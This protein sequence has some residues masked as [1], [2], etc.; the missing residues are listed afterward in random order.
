MAINKKKFEE[1]NNIKFDKINNSLFEIVGVKTNESEHLAA[2]PYSY[3]K[4]VGRSLIKNWTFLICLVL[5]IV[6]VLLAI[7]V[8]WNKEPVPANPDLRPGTGVMLPSLDHIFGLGT[9]GEDFWI[10]IWAG[11]RT[12]LAFA[13]LLAFIQLTIGILLGSIWGYFKKTD[14]FFIQITNF[15]QLV[16]SLI[17][18]LLVIFLFGSSYW[19][20]VLEVSLQA[21]IGIAATIRIQIMLIKNTDYNTASI[22]LGS[23]PNKI[24]RK[25]I[26]PKILPVIVQTGAFSIPG[27]ISID[28]SLSFF[29]FGFVDGQKSTSLG[30]ILNN[31]MAGSAWQEYPHLIILPI[32]L[33]TMV[34]VIFFLVAKVFADSLDPKNHR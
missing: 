15:L 10:E 3:W 7:I 34:S 2:Q 12:T 11:M 5:L 14:I 29:N 27:A 28:A 24:I 16:P 20:I 32:I 23:K 17:L 9:Q 19:P 22:S 26:M 31:I 18:L 13:I 25:N 4:A 8:P 30:K 6:F 33:I 21:W 1:D